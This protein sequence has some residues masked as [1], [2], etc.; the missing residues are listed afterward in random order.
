VVDP[1]VDGRGSVY[2]DEV[3]PDVVW[4]WWWG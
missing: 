4:D 3:K 1:V 2:L